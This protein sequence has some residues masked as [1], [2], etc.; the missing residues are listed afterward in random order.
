L[1][2]NKFV[3]DFQHIDGFSSKDAGSSRN[4]IDHD[5][6]NAIMLKMASNRHNPH[7]KILGI[8]EYGM[9]LTFKNNT[10]AVVVVIVW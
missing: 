1:Y 2:Y 5:D 6:I 3:C 7:L 9:K 10:V 4:K 8:T